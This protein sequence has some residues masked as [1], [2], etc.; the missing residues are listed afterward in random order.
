MIRKTKLSG[1]VSGLR[2]RTE[3]NKEAVILYLLTENHSGDILCSRVFLSISR[4]LSAVTSSDFLKADTVSLRC[5][6]F[7][8]LWVA[9]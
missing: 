2:D 9:G 6:V 4:A 8:K 5:P 7:G 1:R 3:P